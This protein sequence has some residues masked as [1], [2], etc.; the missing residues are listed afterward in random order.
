MRINVPSIVAELETLY[1]DYET[2][3]TANAVKTL[4]E[5]FWNSPLTTRFGI[6]KNLFGNDE[7][8][9]FRQSRPASNLQRTI[10]RIE[11]VKFGA[12]HGEVT[13]EFERTVDDHIVSAR[14]SQLRV[15]F[16]EGWRIVSAHVSLLP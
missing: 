9:S 13:V 2:A 3:L 8:T 5:M 14:Q 12:D 7:I 4:T 16:S 1:P 6:T 10:R 11:V 15:R